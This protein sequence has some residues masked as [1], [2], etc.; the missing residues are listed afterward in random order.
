MAFP[1]FYLG[2]PGDMRALLIPDTGWTDG[3][4][5]YSALT[6]S[7]N[8][9]GTETLFGIKKTWQ[10]ELPGCLPEDRAWLDL[11]WS[12]AV[13][14]L[15]LV[16]PVQPNRFPTTIA[17]TG[18][19]PRGAR[20]FSNTGGS[21]AVVAESDVSPYSV[22][23]SSGTVVSYTGLLALPGETLTVTARL[24][25]NATV[26]PSLTAY[27]AGGSQL[28]SQTGS[29]LASTTTFATAKVSLTAP[30]GTATVKFALT[31]SASANIT[32]NGW[33]ARVDG[34]TVWTTGNGACRVVMTDLSATSP[35]YPVET[36]SATFEQL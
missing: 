16:N 18:G 13:R 31:A 2:K 22:K 4:K 7:L 8:G 35:T 1:T 20:D 25:S 32:T 19:T 17:Q 29:T 9:T 30:S 6:R 28:L 36:V 21:L 23:L 24:H 15:Y 34:S 10:F 14:P 3:D 11:C 27:D 33:L 5:R 12:G 26:T